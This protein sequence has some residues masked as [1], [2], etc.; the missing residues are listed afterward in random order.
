MVYLIQTEPLDSVLKLGLKIT[1]SDSW[2]TGIGLM[3]RVFDRYFLHHL[4]ELTKTLDNREQYEYW[5]T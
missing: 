2:E 1:E 3:K 4:Y 5:S